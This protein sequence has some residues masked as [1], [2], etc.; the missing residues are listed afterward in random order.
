M[1]CLERL[2]LEPPRRRP[3]PRQVCVHCKRH[4]PPEDLVWTYASDPLHRKCLKVYLRDW[5]DL[6]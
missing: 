3:D 5:S 4:I 6:Y 2:L 1:N